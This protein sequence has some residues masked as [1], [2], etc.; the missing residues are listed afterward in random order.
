MCPPYV[1]AN[2]YIYQCPPEK[3]KKMDAYRSPAYTVNVYPDPFH[4]PRMG[5][6][7]SCVILSN[8]KLLHEVGGVSKGTHRVDRRVLGR[9]SFHRQG[10]VRRIDQVNGVV[11]IA[12]GCSLLGLTG[13]MAACKTTEGKERR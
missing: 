8:H 11:Q 1:A 10:W 6:N 13:A 4:P 2:I 7:A 9:D 5:H 12:V 3:E